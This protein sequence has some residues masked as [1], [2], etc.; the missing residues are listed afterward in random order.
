MRFQIMPADPPDTGN[1]C[2]AALEW[3]YQLSQTRQFTDNGPAP[4]TFQ[5]I[6]AWQNLYDMALSPSCIKLIKAADS[7]Y[8]KAMQDEIEE[9][10]RRNR[11]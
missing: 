7:V 3:F 2:E 8:L 5:E 9:D 4:I 10:R 1:D 11:G 6:Q